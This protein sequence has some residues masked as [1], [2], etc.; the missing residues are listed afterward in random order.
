MEKH[1]KN[2]NNRK[3]REHDVKKQGHARCNGPAVLT[4]LPGVPRVVSKTLTALC[5][6][7]PLCAGVPPPPP[8]T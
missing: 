7:F 3:N 4:V 6:F 1:G 5:A 8:E 2:E